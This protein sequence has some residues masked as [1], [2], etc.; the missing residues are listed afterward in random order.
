MN[1]V[2]LSPHFP[3]QQA[4]YARALSRQGARVLG[5]G[6]DPPQGLSPELQTA[7][8]DYFYVP[9]M[10]HYEDLLRTCGQITWKYGR[11]DRIESLNEYWLATDAALRTDFNVPGVHNN[12]IASIKQKS[13]MKRL[14]QEHGIPCAQGIKPASLQEALHFAQEIGYPVVLKPNIGVGAAGTH[15]IQDESELLHHFSTAPES[16][17]LLEEYIAGTIY[18]FDGLAD[19]AGEAVFT[20]SMVY[21]EGVMEV[22]NRDDHIYFYTLRNLPPDL[23]A[24]GRKLLKIFPVAERFFHFEFF[25]RHDNQQLVALEVNL[26]PPGGPSVDMF[27]Y[28]HDIDLYQ[29]WANIVLHNHFNATVERKYHCC[30]AGR[31]AHKAYR[32]SHGEILQQCGAEIVYAAELPGVFRRAMGDYYYLFRSESEER[33][34]EIARFIQAAD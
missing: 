10:H 32:H 17:W 8:S 19:R 30:Y 33:I 12:R 18:T 1:I 3:E 13:E 21:S 22:V 20:T 6:D 34:L 4:R 27:N 14:F 26:R 23:E 9:D 15:L 24:L 16:G 7:L 25:R 29:E 5:V 2:L 28:A 11:I 31:K